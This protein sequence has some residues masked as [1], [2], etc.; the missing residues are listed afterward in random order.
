MEIVFHNPHALWFK[1]NILCYLAG[2]K[3]ISKYDYFF[4]YVYKSNSRIKVLID[5]S[6]QVGLFRG[7]LKFIDNPVYHFY[8]WV[9]LN[10][11][12][13]SKFEIVADVNKL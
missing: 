9:I 5:K 4:D 11:L 3:S 12:D 1:I 2:T 7:S 10:R 13:F 8:A 6:S